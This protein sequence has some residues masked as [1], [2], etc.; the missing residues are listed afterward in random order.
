MKRFL[1]SKKGVTLL[2]GLIALLLLAMVATGAFAVLL[3]TS[4]KSGKPDLEEEMVLAIEHASRELQLRYQLG[5]E[6]DLP[7]QLQ[8]GLC[9]DDSNPFGTSGSH[10]IGCAL[11]SICDTLNSSFSYTV[12]GKSVDSRLKG[13]DVGISYSNQT[14]QITFH[15]TCNGFTL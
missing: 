10:D 4:R 11:P 13:S 12:E 5:G 6:E 2:E 1:Q 7:E 15:I 3:S 9:G 14:P 8:E